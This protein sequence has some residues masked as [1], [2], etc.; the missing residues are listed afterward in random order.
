MEKYKHRVERTNMLQ[1]LSLLFLLNHFC[2]VDRNPGESSAEKQSYNAPAIPTNV[3]RTKLQDGSNAMWM[4]QDRWKK[5]QLALHL[6][7]IILMPKLSSACF[8]GS[9]LHPSMA[10]AFENQGSPIIAENITCFV[11]Q[12]LIQDCLGILIYFQ[13]IIFL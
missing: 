3:S 5:I 4:Q 8:I 9:L 2:R 13:H 10:E 7:Y 6:F 1:R 12:Q 11:F